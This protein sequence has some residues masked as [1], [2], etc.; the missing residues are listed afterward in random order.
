MA[1]PG[2]GDNDLEAID[3]EKE[4]ELWAE[5]AQLSLADGQDE[6]PW[7]ES[8]DY[9]EETGFDW[10][11]IVY[12]VLG[13]VVVGAIL[14]AGWWLTR[15]NGETAL[16]PTGSTIAAPEGPYK[17]RPDDPG[18]AQVAGTGDQAFGVAQG[19][20]TRGRIADGE[21]DSSEARPSVDLDQNASSNRDAGAVYV[22]IGAYSSHADAEQGW[23]Q[24]SSRYGALSGLRHRVREADVN[25]ATVYRLQ[26]IA[27]DRASADATCR[28][29]RDSGGDCYIR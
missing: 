6:L 26:A 22:Q 20:T 12:A 17:Q 13:L 9:E 5:E 4:Q 21:P 18:G 25:G 8:E 15:E 19:E 1:Y 10:R 7:L 11:L 29:I 28:A 3:G 23:S 27:A 2:D 16:A 14:A 24:Q